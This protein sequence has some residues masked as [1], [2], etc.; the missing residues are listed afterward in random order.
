MIQSIILMTSLLFPVT[1]FYHDQYID[2][3]NNEYVV[4]TLVKS[5]DGI[6][7]YASIH[8]YAGNRPL[9]I[10]ININY[11]LTKQTDLCSFSYSHN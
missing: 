9:E 5:Y 2:F 6:F 4:E 3:N 7:R 8:F 11:R 10:D 1:E